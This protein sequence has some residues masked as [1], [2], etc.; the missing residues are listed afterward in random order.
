MTIFPVNS[1][2][3][4]LQSNSLAL[5][6]TGP[7]DVDASPGPN[8]QRTFKE[9]NAMADAPFNHTAPDLQANLA[10]LAY[11]AHRALVLAEVKWPSLADNSA[12]VLL[13]KEA[14]ETFCREYEAS[15]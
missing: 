13:R 11:E 10:A 1:S 9:S 4:H 3:Y 15:L 5:E 14:Y 12:W 8:L 7:K 2:G 6:S